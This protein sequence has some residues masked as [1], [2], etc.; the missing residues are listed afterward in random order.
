MLHLLELVRFT[1]KE[2]SAHQFPIGL[3]FSRILSSPRGPCCN[4]NKKYLSFEKHALL[5]F[6]PGVPEDQ[7]LAKNVGTMRGTF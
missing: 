5:N 7:D 1:A 2:I 6:E 3:F 4:V